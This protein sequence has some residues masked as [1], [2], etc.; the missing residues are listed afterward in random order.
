[1]QDDSR[2]ANSIKNIITGFTGQ[3]VQM[4]LGFVSRMVFVRCLSQDYLGV[5]GLFTNILSMLSLA[6]L[7]IGTA[8]VYA[9][10]KPLADKDEEKL[11]SLMHV[12]SIAYRSIGIIVAVFGLCLIPFLKFFI[13]DPPDIQESLVVIYC[14]YLFNTASSY[15]FTYKTSILNAD[16]KNYIVVG[17]SY[18]V[19]VIQ[20]VAQIIILLNTRNYLL[21]LLCQILFGLTYNF[22]ISY[23]DSGFC[24]ETGERTCF[25]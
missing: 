24:R 7:G 2:T 6:E 18:I 3:A 22:I 19:T 16:Q 9:L 8:I 1:M 12:Y 4:L 23:C 14:L 25:G 17:T 11:A 15:F 13:A 20:T 5:N 21:Y 10:Y